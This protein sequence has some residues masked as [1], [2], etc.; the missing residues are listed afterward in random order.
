MKGFDD[1][2]EKAQK[3]QNIEE[4]IATELYGD[5]VL[6]T[7]KENMKKFL[8]KLYLM[9]EINKFLSLLF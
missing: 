7:I 9:K 5:G 2:A 8:L 4:R 1:M 6:R 3:A